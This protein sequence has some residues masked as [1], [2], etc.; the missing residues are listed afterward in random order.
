MKTIKSNAA[1]L[2]PLPEYRD[3]TPPKRSYKGPPIPPEP[4]PAL[5]LEQE[6]ERDRAMMAAVMQ[7]LQAQFGAGAVS[8]QS[9]Y[10]DGEIVTH[11]EYSKPVKD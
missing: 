10:S 11:A 7:K 2:E 3:P 4:R 1:F 6:K 8:A 9:K 5:T